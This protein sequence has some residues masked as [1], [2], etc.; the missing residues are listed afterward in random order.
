MNA[1]CFDV[2]SATAH[3]HIVFDIDD[4]IVRGVVAV[5][6]SWVVHMKSLSVLVVMII[7]VALAWPLSSLGSVCF[8]TTL[9]SRMAIPGQAL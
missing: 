2:G 3:A 6:H 9:L 5:V 4:T 7:R 1:Y 8:L